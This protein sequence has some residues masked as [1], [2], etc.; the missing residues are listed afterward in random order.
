M[1][2]LTTLLS[3]ICL[4]SFCVFFCACALS[5]RQSGYVLMGHA[6]HLPASAIFPWLAGG[7][8]ARVCVLA[9]VS[10][11]GPSVPVLVSMRL[12]SPS[13]HALERGVLARTLAPAGFPDEQVDPDDV[14]RDHVLRCPGS[15]LQGLPS[16]SQVLVRPV[17]RLW[18]AGRDPTEARRGLS[19]D[20]VSTPRPHRE[21]CALCV[22]VVPSV[23][24]LRACGRSWCTM[25]AHRTRGSRGGVRRG[26]SEDC[27]VGRWSYGSRGSSYRVSWAAGRLRFDGPHSGG[28]V[29][30]A[31]AAEGP[32]WRAELVAQRGGVAG[33]IRLRALSEDASQGGQ[34]RGLSGIDAAGWLCVCVCATPKL[35]KDAGRRTRRAPHCW[36]E[37]GALV[38]SSEEH[39][40]R[41]AALR[42]RYGVGTASMDP[43][44]RPWPTAWFCAVFPQQG[45][46]ILA[47]AAPSGRCDLA[48]RRAPTPRHHS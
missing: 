42:L 44:R 10:S 24:R 33:E 5:G 34:G 20:C 3:R 35:M 2:R 30:G 28:R 9:H 25:A 29:S 46:G 14:R 12:V 6:T 21:R 31:L 26:A 17:V 40:R 8:T 22:C 1:L 11:V 37:F 38:C 19:S 41:S 43:W 16:S 7:F 39:V 47:C 15:L 36:G 18:A 48:R 13:L 45:G 23:S 32:W 27:A 4:T